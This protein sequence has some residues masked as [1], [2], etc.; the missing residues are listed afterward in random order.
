MA[1]FQDVSHPI[2]L[3]NK[4]KQI[5][6]LQVLVRIDMKSVFEMLWP[7][8]ELLDNFFDLVVRL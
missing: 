1:Q 3:R 6:E 5:S 2:I 8:E 7:R 4:L